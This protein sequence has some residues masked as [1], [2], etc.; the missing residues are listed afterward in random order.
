VFGRDEKIGGKRARTK[1]VKYVSTF[2]TD[3][4][5]LHLS[6]SHAEKWE[7]Y[8]NIKSAEDK[9][10][11]FPSEPIALWNTLHTHL[12]SASHLKVFFSAKIV[13]YVIADLLFH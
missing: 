13:E 12:E 7:D 8:Q 6:T 11:L 9:E 10:V 3:G 1:N 2:Q 5:K 4:Y